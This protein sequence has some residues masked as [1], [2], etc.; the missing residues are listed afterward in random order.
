VLGLREVGGWQ[1]LLSRLPPDH[2]HGVAVLASAEA[3]PMGV[4]WYAVVFGLTIFAG[5]SYWC[6]DFLVVQR[7][8]AARNML[9]ARRTPL[10]AAFFK[11]LFPFLIILPG[12]LGTAL[13]RERIEGQP[14]LVVPILM[15]RY[16]S[17]GMLGLGLTAL[18]AS[19]MSGMAGNVTAF[20]TVWTYDIYR[21]LIAPGRTD[22]HY[23][24]MGRI[25]TVVGTLLS[26]GASYL[27][28]RF[29]NMGDY[30]VL[31]FSLFM[32]PMSTAFLLG[33]FW[34][35]TSATGAFYG[36]MSGVSA[37]IAHYLLYHY[38]LIHYRTEMAANLYIIIVGWLAGCSVT[39]ALS[40][41]ASPRPDRE[42]DG[43]VYSPLEVL[44]RERVRWRESPELWAILLFL[45][46]L[47]LLVV[48]W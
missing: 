39:I 26:V 1:G 43:L 36:M 10:I 33:M 47:A 40:L 17:Q 7:A 21:A 42:L 44:R 32:F 31:V 2:G 45:M 3:N 20:N 9:A 6:T 22:S 4:P 30:L 23:L 28:M 19:F 14:N 35:R 12:L 46:L 29:H 5:T 18:L 41:C 11:M 48:F 24:G 16:Y 34:K 15:E 8:L 25:T 13:F 37:S 27:V 38:G